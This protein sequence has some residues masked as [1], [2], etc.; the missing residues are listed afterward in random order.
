MASYYIPLLATNRL[1]SH[2]IYSIRQLL[3]SKNETF[4]Q[5]SSPLWSSSILVYNP[6]SLSFS[7]S[8]LP[9]VQLFAPRPSGELNRLIPKSN[10]GIALPQ[11]CYS[12]SRPS[13][14]RSSS[15]CL[16]NRPI[17]RCLNTLVVAPLAYARALS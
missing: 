17:G 15:I 13:R 16:Y 5:L 12:C 14:I 11:Y 4:A 1:T 8:P 7:S 6:P 2:L 3:S 10:D 9:F